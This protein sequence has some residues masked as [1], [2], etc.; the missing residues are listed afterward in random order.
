MRRRTLLLTRFRR[1]ATSSGLVGTSSELIATSS[2]LVGTS[3]ELIVTSSGLVDTSSELIATSSG[4]VGT[5]LALIAMSSVLIDTSLA[6]ITTSFELVATTL[7]RNAMRCLFDWGLAGLLHR[8]SW[9]MVTRRMKAM[10]IVLRRS[11]TMPGADGTALRATDAWPAQSD[12]GVGVARGLLC[13]LR[14]IDMASRSVSRPAP[15]PL[16]RAMA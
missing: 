3:L 2:R 16:T 1:G 7:R 12:D 9:Q 4:L 8:D 5:S 14:R 15:L 11:G 10:T 13:R 6:L